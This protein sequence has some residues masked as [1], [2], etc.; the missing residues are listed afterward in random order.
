[1]AANAART[2]LLTPH[3]ALPPAGLPAPTRPDANTEPRRVRGTGWG[4]AFAA[5]K[6]RKGPT[7][8]S[9]A[10]PLPAARC[11][12]FTPPSAAPRAG[13]GTAPATARRGAHLPLAVGLHQLAERRVPL[14]LELH[15]GAILPGHLQVDVVVLCLH[16]FLGGKTGRAEISARPGPTL[17]PS[18]SARGPPRARQAPAAPRR[19]HLGLLLRHG[20][21]HGP[22]GSGRGGEGPARALPPAAA[23][24]N[25]PRERA[26]SRAAAAPRQQRR[27][28]IGRPAGHVKGGGR[29]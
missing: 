6:Q 29:G 28:P 20:G 13:T 8:S 11:P 9:K 10:Q 18:S 12:S 17:P 16:S 21:R 3:T 14:D 22:G 25:R 5:G 4:R 23:A 19:A 15:D 2:P 1:M 24:A 7:C 26:P 27:A